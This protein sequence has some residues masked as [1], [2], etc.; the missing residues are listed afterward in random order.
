MDGGAFLGDVKPPGLD[1]CWR[2]DRMGT[3]ASKSYMG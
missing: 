2:V 1:I 3:Y